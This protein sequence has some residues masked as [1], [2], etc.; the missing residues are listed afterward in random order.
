M[1]IVDGL[2]RFI[3]VS[4]LNRR[5]FSQKRTISEVNTRNAVTIV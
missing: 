2:G 5:V 1:P 3:C 4:V